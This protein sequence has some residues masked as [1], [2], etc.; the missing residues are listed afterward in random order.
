M[1]VPP[2]R[3]F[4]HMLPS[5]LRP[6]I[7]LQATEPD[8][9]PIY[10]SWVNMACFLKAPDC[11][12][13]LGLPPVAMGAYNPDDDYEDHGCTCN[14][15]YKQAEASDGCLSLLKEQHPYL[16]SGRI[17]LKAVMLPRHRQSNPGG[18]YDDPYGMY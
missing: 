17:R 4:A 11:R 6:G 14:A 3:F 8:R 10:T 2:D 12:S 1:C 9:H 15:S 18:G 13:T 5:M 7:N 16:C